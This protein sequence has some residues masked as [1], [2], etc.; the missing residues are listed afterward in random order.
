M[1]NLIPFLVQ[2][3]L[4]ALKSHDYFPINSYCVQAEKV[5][6]QDLYFKKAVKFV[7]EPMSHLESIA[8]S[9]VRFLVAPSN[10]LDWFC[11]SFSDNI[12]LLACSKDY[13]L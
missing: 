4:F 6:N 7:G 11:D 8:S 3:L 13:Y 2:W 12:L 9:A 1:V 5:H 10:F